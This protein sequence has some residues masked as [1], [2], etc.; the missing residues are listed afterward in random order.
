ML[1]TVQGNY[2]IEEGSLSENVVIK[3]RFK[4]DSGGLENKVH[5]YTMTFSDDGMS[6]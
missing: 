6:G 4:A 2:P 5:S 1:A 3:P